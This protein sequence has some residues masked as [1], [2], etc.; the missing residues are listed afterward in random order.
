MFFQRVNS[1]LR[2]PKTSVF[3]SVNRGDVWLHNASAIYALKPS[4]NLFF[5]L[6]NF[7]KN[8]IPPRSPSSCLPR[9][10]T[11]SDLIVGREM[12]RRRAWGMSALTNRIFR[13]VVAA[14]ALALATAAAAF[15]PAVVAAQERPVAMQPVAANANVQAQPIAFST[16]ND[17]NRSVR[18]V[19]AGA[20]EA[21][22]DKI[23][24]V[25]WGGNR[26][27]QQQAYNAALDLR[28][29]G[30][31]LAF[32]VGPSLDPANAQNY[33]HIDIYA[34]GLPGGGDGPSIII[35]SERASELRPMLVGE[36]QRTYAIA[37]PTQVAALDIR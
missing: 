25:I 32:I 14:P 22:R 1:H 21:S 20:A 18:F 29:Q 15:S 7:N 5:F 2:L 34:A 10:L 31:P 36:A 12:T 8:R 27:L 11:E 4:N 33:A 6:D 28:D 26:E 35:G 19:Q 9:C 24:I 13:N 23:A 37:F 3:V 16:F 30:I 17:S